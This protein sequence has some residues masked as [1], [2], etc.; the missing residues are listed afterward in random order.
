MIC[1]VSDG[2]RGSDA[3]RVD[4]SWSVYT[5]IQASTD[6]DEVLKAIKKGLVR[7]GQKEKSTF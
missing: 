1:I 2:A 7:V 3:H 6:L 5:E 4:E